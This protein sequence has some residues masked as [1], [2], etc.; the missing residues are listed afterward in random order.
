MLKI[1]S[2]L[3]F[4]LA[5]LKEEGNVRFHVVD[6]E[7]VLDIKTNVKFHLYD[8]YCK[9]THDDK[10]IMLLNYLTEEE[11]N[12]IWEIKQAIT[13]PKTAQAKRDDYP[14]MVQRQREIFSSL[15]ENPVPTQ[16]SKMMNIV[17]EEGA[18]EYR[19]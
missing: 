16:T 18:E 7:H 8:D 15:Y 11:R 6:E 19:G 5:S 10:T 12:L 4:V 3:G 13:D 2:I 9:I 1:A 17:S 14:N